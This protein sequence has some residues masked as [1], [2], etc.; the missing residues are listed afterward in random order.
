MSVVSYH[1]CVYVIGGF[2]FESNFATDTNTILKFYSNTHM[3]EGL[4]M[5]TS[6][7]EAGAIIV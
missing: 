1:N 5:P 7:A 3:S 4:A 6:R 2:E